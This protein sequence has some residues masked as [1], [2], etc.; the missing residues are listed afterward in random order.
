MEGRSRSVVIVDDGR[1]ARGFLADADEVFG[2]DQTAG[3]T[4]DDV[5]RDETAELKPCQSRAVHANPC[6]LTDDDVCICGRIVGK[7]TVKKKYDGKRR[8]GERHEQQGKESPA[9]PDEGQGLRENV[10]QASPADERERKR[11]KPEWFE[12]EGFGHW[13]DYTLK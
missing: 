9:R 5:K 1:A 2:G 6:G 13:V 4:E 11:R 10:I 8:A 12:I 7:A 3:E